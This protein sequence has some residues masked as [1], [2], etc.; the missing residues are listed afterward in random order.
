MLLC[1]WGELRL[2]KS[3]AMPLQLAVLQAVRPWTAV[4]QATSPPGWSRWL[5]PGPAE[6]GRQGWQVLTKHPTRPQQAAT[7]HPAHQPPSRPRP[8]L[9]GRANGSCVDTFVH[10]A[11]TR[12]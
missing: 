12:G 6:H 8:T 9:S 1:R 5:A 3:A 2:D 4:V 10:A 7:S 11:G